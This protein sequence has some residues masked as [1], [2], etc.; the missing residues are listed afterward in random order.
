MMGGCGGYRGEG[1]A[2]KDSNDAVIN[3]SRDANII[4]MWKRD[5]FGGAMPL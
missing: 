5:E 1:G 4:S 3:N 2:G